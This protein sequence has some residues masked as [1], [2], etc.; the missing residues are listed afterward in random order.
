MIRIILLLT[1]IIL[2]GG[3]FGC[4]RQPTRGQAAKWY[5][6]HKPTIDAID[7]ELRKAVLAMPY[8]QNAFRCDPSKHPKTI[9]KA[10]SPEIQR[11]QKAFAPIVA[12][13]HCTHQKL[14]WIQ[15]HNK[16]VRTFQKKL[17]PNLLRHPGVLGIVIDS[18]KAGDSLWSQ[19]GRIGSTGGGRHD[20]RL[21]RKS[22]LQRDGRRIGWG[23]FQTA[24]Q[25]FGG[26]GRRYGDGKTHPGIL[27]SWKFESPTKTRFIV[28]VVVM[29]HHRTTA[30]WRAGW[31]SDHAAR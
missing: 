22:V 21:K 6:A 7:Q 1:C 12:D 14:E 20:R 5:K 4:R 2:G 18:Y 24:Y 17:L 23:T 10:P 27:V 3:H 31:R 11:I 28:T 9:T 16:R 26:A 25:T 30:K 8:F 15:E 19:L 29:A 13:L